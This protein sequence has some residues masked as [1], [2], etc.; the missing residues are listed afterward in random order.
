MYTGQ[1]VFARRSRPATHTTKNAV[2]Y[3]YYVSQ[4]YLRGITP[5]PGA[6]TRVP[7]ADIEAAVIRALKTNLRSAPWSAGAEN[8]FDHDMIASSVSCIEIRK[9]LWPFGSGLHHLMP[10]T[11]IKLV[12]GLRDQQATRTPRRC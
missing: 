5:P 9:D 1:Y 2:R 8:L 11:S 6:I 12:M 4:P 10:P 7:A 3:H